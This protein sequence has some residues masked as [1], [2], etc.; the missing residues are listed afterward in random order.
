MLY[1]ANLVNQYATDFNAGHACVGGRSDNMISVND[2]H[3]S[4]GT[5]T[6]NQSKKLMRGQASFKGEHRDIRHVRASFLVSCSSMRIPTL[7]IQ[8]IPDLKGRKIVYRRRHRFGASG[9]ADLDV[10]ALLQT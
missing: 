1:F 9:Q 2:G 5:S 3:A 10:S 8:S 4:F 7:N 6:R